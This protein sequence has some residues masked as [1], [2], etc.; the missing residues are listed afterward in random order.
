M[1]LE[2]LLQCSQQLV[3]IL[4]RINPVHTTS[5]YLFKNRITWLVF[6]FKETQYIPCEK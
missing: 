2:G 3:P 4:S 6:F 5:F 1:E